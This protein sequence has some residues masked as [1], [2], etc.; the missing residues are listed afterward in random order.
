MQCLVSLVRSVLVGTTRVG[1]VGKANFYLAGDL[2][3]KLGTTMFDLSA[4]FSSDLRLC[5][6]TFA[7][8]VRTSVFLGRPRLRFI[9]LLAITICADGVTFCTIFS[10]LVMKRFIACFISVY[11]AFRG[12]PRLRFSRGSS[13]WMERCLLIQQIWN[14]CLSALT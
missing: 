13:A 14:E 8:S 7:G 3:R 1:V 6:T 9:S 4:Y 2:P 12:L 11:V 10:V 5:L